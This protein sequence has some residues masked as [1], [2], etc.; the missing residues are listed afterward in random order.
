M[1]GRNAGEV[2]SRLAV[3]VIQ[4]HIHEARQDEN[5]SFIGEYDR[6]FSSPTNRLASAIRLANA[7]VHASAKSHP[8]QEGMGTTVVSG[9]LN[10]QILCI[11]HV[12]DS[13]MY[14]VRGMTIEPLTADHSLVAEQV[15]RGLLTEEEAERSPQRNIITRA[16]GID[17][18][19]D[20]ELDEVPL[21]R[22]DAVLL[23]SDGLTKGVKP[24]EILSAIR[25]A[26]SSAAASERLVTLANAAG[27]D[28]NTSVI[29]LMLDSLD[30]ASIWRRA[31]DWVLSLVHALHVNE[32]MTMPKLF[33]KFNEA[34]DKEI[35]MEGPQLTIGRKPDEDVALDNP[36]VP[37][38]Q[39]R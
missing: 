9:L 18:T 37:G 14:L 39:D 16:L 33:L 22:G 36:T 10:D 24:A 30:R 4:K 38:R 28:D 26:E 20:V 7:T 23:C 27:G 19:V 35:A 1:G 32:G 21:M 2:A 5:L 34:V 17:D 11:A 29:V 31:W 25:G 3:E 13:R 8:G 15:R 6:R 12:G